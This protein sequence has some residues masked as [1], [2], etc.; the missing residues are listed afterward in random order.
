MTT[1]ALDMSTKTGW[2]LFNESAQPVRFGKII[3]ETKW[4]SLEY[5]KNFIQISEEMATE[6]SKL[7]TPDVTDV[8]IEEIN[9][10]SSRFGS[11]F[12]QKLLDF[13]HFAVAKKLL[14][15]PVKIHYINTSD[16]RK[17]LKLSVAET[18][19]IAKPLLKVHNELKKRWENEKDKKLKKLLEQEVRAS[20]EGLKAMC[21][22]GKIDKKSI[23]VAYANATWKMT[24]NKGDNDIT[25]ALCQGKAFLAGAPT[26]TNKD[27][28]ERG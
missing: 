19:K 7:I 25:D 26:V 10:T 9:K 23:S 4:D 22:H 13:I 15:L 18:R 11:R 28:F 2:A 1:L 5:P 17:V 12:S 24:F 27:I 21:I 6:I 20:K 3:N 8:V 16:W 14:D